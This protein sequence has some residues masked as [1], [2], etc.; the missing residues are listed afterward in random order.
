MIAMK[1]LLKPLLLLLT[2]LLL[3]GASDAFIKSK[4]PASPA[5]FQPGIQVFNNPALEAGQSSTLAASGV[6]VDAAS[7][8]LVQEIH[9][10]VNQRRADLVPSTQGW[11]HL[12]IRRYQS[13]GDSSTAS[14][15]PDDP[16]QL[17]QWLSLDAQGRVV[18]GVQRSLSA[19][20]DDSVFLSGD[21]WVSLP[22]AGF[23]ATSST[24][25]FDPSYG[26]DLLVTGLVSQGQTL[27]KSLLYKECWYQGDKYTL[28][29]G[30]LLHEIVVKPDTHALRWIKTWQVNDGGIILIDSLEIALEERLPQPPQDIQGLAGQKIP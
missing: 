7:A 24:L 28:S 4:L 12:I 30:H 20:G 5:A 26:L 16:L 10:L 29:D 25:P 22:L 18:A 27:N 6:P 15:S 3:L 23:S 8:T 11:V 9:T 13:T 1:F 14:R 21:K 17:E 19:Q 2:G